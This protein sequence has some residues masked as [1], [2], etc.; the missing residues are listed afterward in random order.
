MGVVRP[1]ERISGLC[2]PNRVEIVHVM[3]A[4]FSHAKQAKI[5]KP[6]IHFGRRFC[7]GCVLKDD[8]NTIDFEFNPRLIDGL[9]WR[10]EARGTQR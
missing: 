3:S 4:V 8:A 9:G 6:K 10:D 1:S 5:R 7:V 2:A